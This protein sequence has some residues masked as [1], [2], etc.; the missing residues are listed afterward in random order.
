MKK[1]LKRTCAIA[2]AVAAT[3]GVTS[4]Q[5]V[6]V[7]NNFGNNGVKFTASATS[8]V[9]NVLTISK[10]DAKNVNLG[11][12]FEVPT[13]T[14]DGTPVTTYTVKTPS[15]RTFDNTD[16]NNGKFTVDEIG[17]YTITFKSGDYEGSTTFVSSRSKYTITFVENTSR[18]LPNKVGTDFD[19]DIYVP[20]FKITNAKKDDVTEQLAEN[21]E[22]KVSS[23]TSTYDVDGNGKVL[24]GDAE[25]E[26]GTYIVTYTLY[27]TNDPATRH[28]LTSETKEFRVVDG[29]AYTSDKL[30][31]SYS[32]EKPSS[33]NLGRTVKLPKVTATLD[34]SAINTYYTVEVLKNGRDAVDA[35]TDVNGTKVLKLNEDGVY[36]FTAKELANYYTFKYTVH[37][38]VGHEA[39]TEFVVDTVEDTVK[40]TPIIVDAYDKT[41][42][43]AVAALK[44]KQYA[45]PSYFGTTGTV[46]IMAVYAEDLGTFNFADYKFKRVIRNSSYQTIYTDET[47][48]NKTLVFNYTGNEEDLA[49][50]QKLAKDE[51]D[52]PITLRDGTYY[53][54]YYATDK[55]GNQNS[56][57][58]KFVID[59]EYQDH[60]FG[61]EEIKPVVKFSDTFFAS[62]DKGETIEFSSPTFSDDKDEYLYTE[63]YYQYYNG[64]NAIGGEDGKI[65]LTETNANKKYVIDTNEEAAVG[66][67][68]VVITALATNDAEFTTTETREIAINSTV[69]N[70]D[71]PTI[72]DIDDGDYVR[73][74]EQGTEITIPALTFE[75]ESE[76][77]RD[78]IVVDVSI[79]CKN[80]DETINYKANGGY[81][82]AFGNYYRFSG[83]KFVAATAGEYLVSVKATDAAGNVVIKFIEYTVADATYTG[84]LRFASIGLNDT[85]IELGESFKLPTAK[86]VGTGSENYAYL[87]M[88][89]GSQYIV[90]DRFTPP[91]VGEYK[92]KYVMYEAGT[93][94]ETT[95][96]EEETV[97]FTITVEDTTKPE[98]YVDWNLDAAYEKGEHALLPIFSAGDV[99]GIDETRSLITVTNSKNSSTTTIK[100]ADMATE[101]NKG[102]AGRMYISLDKDAEY[103]V[104]Y[105]V[106]DNQGNVTKQTHTIKVGDLDAPILTVNDKVV[107][108]KYNI[109]DEINIDLTRNDNNYF[110]IQGGDEKATVENITIKLTRDGTEVD[111]LETASDSVYRFALKQAGSYELTFTV[112][113]EA[114]NTSETVRKTFEI[115]EKAENAMSRTQV[116]GTI[117]IVLS[118]VVLGGV[119]VY[120]IVSKR[121]MDKLY[122]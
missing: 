49:A 84:A 114:G 87:V 42:A 30:E 58:H 100:F 99:S 60:R 119:V 31:L 9:T 115:A 109:G 75:A 53:V 90:N 24:F 46:E 95:A 47:D 15:G 26:R 81:R 69:I 40:P 43:E 57:T 94:P 6:A 110:V 102:D 23:L 79:V 5:N 13:A 16:V 8:P 39:T 106:Y 37:D 10:Y 28:Y 48:P 112:T 78:T 83:A 36:E 14:L 29:S 73:D 122:K 67:T 118:V 20:D 4:A 34:G 105:T 77:A 98:V 93:D 62:V 88:G 97:E 92:L 56:L 76:T 33:I 80:D 25:L 59:A 41:D 65:Y 35:N 11:D 12:E 7:K 89:E 82:V 27:S 64:D 45:M 91:A 55:A 3:A 68:K 96:V 50:T 74:V 66:A 71:A 63:V 103:T 116:V 104:T 38:M 121:K 61:N 111:D 17:T 54:Y 108:N 2:L 51:N 117:L 32:S 70:N 113:D 44:D 52:E 19:G 86:I 107:K 22:I 120:F 85:T 18:T 1:M 101:Y 21:V 72:I